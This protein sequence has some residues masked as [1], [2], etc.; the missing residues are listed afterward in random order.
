[1]ILKLHDT[2]DPN[3]LVIVVTNELLAYPSRGPNGNTSV[4]TVVG[5]IGVRESGEE[6]AAQIEAQAGGAA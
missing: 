6:I 1:M 4:Q 5:I 3:K 2:F